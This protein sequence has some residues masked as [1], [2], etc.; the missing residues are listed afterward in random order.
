M[1]SE[2]FPPGALTEASD[3]SCPAAEAVLP[4]KSTSPL[5]DLKFPDWP[6]DTRSQ[7]L[8]NTNTVASVPRGSGTVAVPGQTPEPPLCPYNG[9]KSIA[10]PSSGSSGPAAWPIA[11]SSPAIDVQ[12]PTG[13]SMYSDIKRTVCTGVPGLPTMGAAGTDLDAGVAWNKWLGSLEMTDD[14]V[15]DSSGALPKPS[16]RG[17][18]RIA[19]N[20]DSR[21]NRVVFDNGSAV[22]G[23][24][25]ASDTN[26]PNSNR[27]ACL[28]PLNIDVH[29]I[30]TQAGSKPGDADPLKS[31]RPFI[32]CLH[33]KWGT[34]CKDIGD[35]S[36][37]QQATGENGSY[38]SGSG[39]CTFQPIKPCWDHGGV[40]RENV[41]LATTDV[42]L[43]VDGDVKD[44]G[45]RQ[46]LRLRMMGDDINGIDINNPG[47]NQP[48][49]GRGIQ[50]PSCCPK[51]PKGA[52]AGSEPFCCAKQLPKY[53]TGP[54]SKIKC[55]SLAY[56]ETAYSKYDLVYRGGT[57]YYDDDH[58]PYA[59][60]GAAI[61]TTGMFGPSRMTVVMRAEKTSWKETDGRGY[62][63]AMWGF[64]YNE[65]YPF[66]A[67]SCC[68]TAPGCYPA[69]KACGSTTGASNA[70]SLASVGITRPRTKARSTRV[71]LQKG[72]GG[73][74]TA[75]PPPDGVKGCDPNPPSNALSPAPVAN[76]DARGV[77]MC[78]PAGGG[79]S[80]RVD[81]DAESQA[82]RCEAMR[83]GVQGSY[84]CGYYM[85]SNLEIDIEIPSNAPMLNRDPSGGSSAD[86][87]GGWSSAVN[88]DLWKKNTTWSTMNLVPW[89][90]DKDIYTGYKNLY[91]Q[92]TL[93]RTDAAAD[94]TP[95]T[96]VSDD[97]EFHAYTIEWVPL[98]GD[99][100]FVRFYFDGKVVWET[101]RFTPK[102]AMRLVVGP[103]P[104]WWG[105]GGQPG[106][107]DQAF[108]DIA[109]IKIE[110]ITEDALG[111]TRSPKLFLDWSNIPQAFDQRTST[112]S[113]YTCGFEEMPVVKRPARSGLSTTAIVLIVVFSVVLAV[114][115]T[116]GGLYMYKKKKAARNSV[117]AR[118]DRGLKDA[119]KAAALGSEQQLRLVNAL[120]EAATN[121][122]IM[123]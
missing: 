27:T 25:V 70:S 82:W 66:E 102:G 7:P 107:F 85:N 109:S 101:R 57:P 41:F 91:Q 13:G 58:R 119:K 100:A 62:V 77:N 80:E 60:T 89:V 104:A 19:F 87:D 59:R 47:K 108:V 26:S 22:V 78:G 75:P 88:V 17:Y 54:F 36:G 49:L 21:G 55:N 37:S 93:T 23:G 35:C 2:S 97:G 53:K 15:P 115:A 106:K 90:A 71:L 95:K 96:W 86:A 16:D 10:P 122:V 20:V 111:I 112:D 6:G 81:A 18:K 64:G 110:P 105:T 113:S 118:L 94:G 69:V 1:S 114:A 32:M 65:M 52:E 38:T 46:V 67:N 14:R 61:A 28:Q 84:M 50:L 30:T 3:D 44:Y 73:L 74:R 120:T 63:I 4:A 40:I 98:N 48:P 99:K 121:K 29:D 72:G 116:V 103:W 68:K 31:L 56:D 34:E 45:Q 123:G 51:C 83:H 9:D 76:C 117:A 33:K 39:N 42:K 11:G 8:L 12:N 5:L 43:S 79:L 24:A 92:Q